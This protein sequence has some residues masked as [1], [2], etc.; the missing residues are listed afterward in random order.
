[1]T[2]GAHLVIPLKSSSGSKQ[3]LAG[4]LGR[5]EREL[6]S[7]S[8]GV[9]AVGLAAQVWPRGR[10][11]VVSAEQNLASTCDRLGV[12]RVSDSGWGQSA[13]VR[14]GVCWCLERGATTVATI[15]ADLPALRE[16]DLEEVLAAAEAAPLGSMTVFPDTGGTG[17]NGVVVSPGSLL[18]HAFG[19][20][21]RRRHERIAAALGLRFE[22]V[23]LPGLRWD[24]DRPEDLEQAQAPGA[25]GHPLVAWAAD[26]RRLLT[27]ESA[28]HGDP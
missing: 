12:A 18:V 19:P 6:V 25:A 2:A 26:S 28:C 21:S 14:S 27:K 4:S 15:A 22:V 20:G 1:V 7:L 17:T 10:V 8:L 11:V 13:A 24:L 16:G 3:R 23:D 9:R 5:W